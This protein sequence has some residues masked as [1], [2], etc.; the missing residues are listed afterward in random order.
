MDLLSNESLIEVYM[1]AKNNDLNEDFL[2]LVLEEIKR[3]NIE[4]PMTHT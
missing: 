2:K 4:L 3:R 1:A